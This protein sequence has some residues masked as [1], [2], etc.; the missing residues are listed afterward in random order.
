M[1]QNSIK[2]LFTLLFATIL[3]L[4]YLSAQNFLPVGTL[5]TMNFC[6]EVGK[7]YLDEDNDADGIPDYFLYLRNNFR[8][9]AENPATYNA[10]Q[11]FQFPD[12]ND[13]N[14]T[15]V[16]YYAS[17]PNVLTKKDVTATTYSA[18][19][20][21][22]FKRASRVFPYNQRVRGI[23]TLNTK[24]NFEKPITTGAD[25]TVSILYRYKYSRAIPPTTTPTSSYRYNQV[26]WPGDG[27]GLTSLNYINF[28]WPTRTW[29]AIE[30]R[31]D[32]KNYT[33]YRCGDGIKSTRT[34]NGWRVNSSFTGEVCD[35]GVNNGQAGYCNATC[36]GTWWGAFFCGDS[37][38]ND[39]PEGTAVYLSGD[40]Q[41]HGPNYYSWT[42]LMF[43]TCDNGNDPNDPDGQF[44]QDGTGQFCS[45]ICFDNFTEAFV[46][47]FIND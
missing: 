15:K 32:C 27:S 3:S 17:N 10:W 34:S 33:M 44:N 39:E 12:S 45:S 7:L 9:F 28:S 1:K 18:L 37:I 25:K 14:N 35:D 6:S 5:S 36:S 26:S 4:G 40:G 46:E 47:E 42:E 43:E 13:V 31:E 29:H 30:T 41:Y 22:T 11:I 38:I 19:D 2:T 8:L 20:N 23:D 21:T 24:I 16:F